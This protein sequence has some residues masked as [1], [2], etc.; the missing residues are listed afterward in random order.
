M[1]QTTYLELSED[2]GSAHKF[3]EVTVDGAEMSI[4]YGRIGDP[5]QLED[6]RP[7]PT[8]PRRRPR[9]RRRS[10]RRSARATPR[11]SSASAPEALRLPP[12]QI[13][14][15]RSTAT[16]RPGAVALQVGRPRLRHLRRRGA[17]LGRQR[18]RRHLHPHPRRQG[19]RPVPP[20][21]R[22]EVHRR[23]RRLA[24]RRLRRRQRLRPVRQGA[25]AWPTRS[26]RTSTSTGSTSTT[27]SSASPT[28]RAASLQHRPR[29]RVPVAPPGQGL[30]R[31]D[32]A[33]RRRRRATTATRK[34]VTSYDWRTGT[35]A[36]APADHAARCCSAGRSATPSTPACPPTPGATASPRRRPRPASL[37]LRRRRSSPA[38]PPPDG[39]L[40]LRRRQPAPRSTASTRRA[41]GCGSSAPAAARPTRCSTTTTGSTSS[42][43]TARWPASTPARRPIRA[44]E[45]GAVPEY[46]DVK[47]PRMEAVA[48]APTTVE[49]DHATPAGGVVVECF[50][51]GGRAARPGR[52][53]RLP[54]RLAGA[55]PQG[56]PRAGRPLRGR[57]RSA[58]RAAAASTAPTAT[59]AASSDR[60]RCRP[61][62]STSTRRLR[63]CLVPPSR[64]RACRL[65]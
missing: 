30:Q 13:V 14:S 42:P 10:A 43:P 64:R 39:K 8:T 57:R 33:L 34:G 53:A 32:G 7:I 29:G 60:R 17:L 48:A 19:A 40:R 44:A 62:R 24:L 12:R 56:H 41:T 63:H 6:H 15:A 31:L 2:S 27:A 16:D 55:V 45:Q 65:V 52:L 38:P 49:V 47:A 23:R 1:P 11:P 35:R 46:V 26:P 9:R 58:R 3:Y 28:P 20:P 54:R 37:P 21:R 51:E 18:G 50:E 61:G 59:S 4:R 25:R 36:V 5:G 22:R